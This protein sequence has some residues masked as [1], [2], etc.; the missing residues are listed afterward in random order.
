MV[1]SCLLNKFLHSGGA[2]C[3]ETSV[4]LVIAFARQDGCLVAR[5]QKTEERSKP[6]KKSEE[7]NPKKQRCLSYLFRVILNTFPKYSSCL[8]FFSLYLSLL[9]YFNLSLCKYMQPPQKNLGPR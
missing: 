3:N 6:Q 1:T 9:I 2:T 4:L 7:T 8:N 5:Y